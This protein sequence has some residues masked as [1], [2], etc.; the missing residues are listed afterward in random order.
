[1]DYFKHLLNNIFSFD[2]I[3]FKAIVAVWL[4]F[5]GIQTYLIV[6]P[7]LIIFDVITGIYSSIKKG[8]K[9]TSRYLK[10]GLLEKLGLYLI[11]FLSSFSLEMVIKTIFPWESYF[12]VFFVTVLIST[13]EITSICEN[14]FT[15]NPSLSFLTSLIRLSKKLNDKAVEVA[16]GKIDGADIDK[17][18][19]NIPK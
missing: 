15:I 13:Y 19:E 6:I 2:N 1:M 4:Y 12:I 7:V 3:I 5:A 16:E 17:K 10:K 14:V 8:D 18:E 11:L 9:F